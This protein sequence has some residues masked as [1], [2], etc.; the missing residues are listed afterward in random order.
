M[1]IT[2]HFRVTREQVLELSALIEPRMSKPAAALLYLVGFL[3]TTLFVHF[4]L[5]ARLVG[6]WKKANQFVLAGGASAILV[7]SAY[8]KRTTE[9]KSIPEF[10]EVD[11]KYQNADTGVARETAIETAKMHWPYYQGFKE[12]SN[13]FVLLNKEKEASDIIPKQAFAS[14]QGLNAL[15]EMLS[16]HLVS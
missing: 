7:G 4:V 2:T 3:L 14:E 10:V 8:V 5:S 11:F 13:Y 15:R 12:L 9:K 6:N 16:K 1:M